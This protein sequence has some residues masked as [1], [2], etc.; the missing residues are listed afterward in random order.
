M[1]QGD[2]R[3]ARSASCGARPEAAARAEE[4][5]LLRGLDGP[6]RLAAPHLLTNMRTQL[7]VRLGSDMTLQGSNVVAS[8]AKMLAPARLLDLLLRCVQAHH[9]F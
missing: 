7:C 5:R 4:K 3:K 2:G 1:L 8:S 6:V 9:H